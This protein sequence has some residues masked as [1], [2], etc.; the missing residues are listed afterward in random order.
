MN[1]LGCEDIFGEWFGRHRVFGAMAFVCVNRQSLKYPAS[2]NDEPVVV[3]HI[4]HGDLLIGHLLDDPHELSA[5]VSLWQS[6]DIADFV[7]GATSLLAARLPQLLYR[8]A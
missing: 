8:T 3:T 6:T 5:A 4:A 7:T 2:R 1:G